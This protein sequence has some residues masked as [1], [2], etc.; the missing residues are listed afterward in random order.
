MKYACFTV[1]VLLSVVLRSELCRRNLNRFHQLCVP[2]FFVEK[3]LH[4]YVNNKF[5]NVRSKTDL[6][7]SVKQELKSGYGSS[8][9][10]F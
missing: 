1:Y 7:I 10:F 2:A 4:S 8:G 3:G 9:S 5:N 6:K